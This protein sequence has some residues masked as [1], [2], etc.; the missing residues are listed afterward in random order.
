MVSLCDTEWGNLNKFSKFAKFVKMVRAQR[1][2]YDLSS[3]M[4]SQRIH[5]STPVSDIHT[6]TLA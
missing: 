5:V 3:P 4:I 2:K 1:V 6:Y